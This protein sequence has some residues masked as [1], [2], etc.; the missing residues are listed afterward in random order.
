MI[1]LLRARALGQASAELSDD[2][3]NSE[4]LGIL[5]PLANSLLMPLPALGSMSNL[6]LTWRD[7]AN[8]L[9]GAELAAV[10][11]VIEHVSLRTN[12]STWW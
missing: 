10:G 4:T 7:F 8:T 9:A 5:C 2:E 1:D 12:L 11:V 3:R 6:R